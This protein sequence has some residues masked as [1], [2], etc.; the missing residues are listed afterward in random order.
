ML[1]V[2][3][4]RKKY[5]VAGFFF[6]PNVQPQKEYEKRLDQVKKLSKIQGWKLF[7]GEYDVERWFKRVKDNKWDG[8]YSARCL[9]CITHSLENTARLALK[10]GYGNFTTVLTNSPKKDVEMI[11]RIGKGI[12]EKYGV[13]F[14]KTVF[15]KDNGYPKSVNM[16]KKMNIYRQNYCGCIFSKAERGLIDIKEKV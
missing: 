9:K 15:R 11:N 14:L 3:I 12:G 1:A 2:P 10:E 7:I 4:M 13:N 8:E 5:D 6:N 16:T